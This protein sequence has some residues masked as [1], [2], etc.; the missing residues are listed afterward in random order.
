MVILKIPH[1]NQI[2]QKMALLL[3]CLFSFTTV[4]ASDPNP[5][6]NTPISVPS[7]F[8]LGNSDYCPLLSIE[9]KKS[10]A[11]KTY[12]QTGIG[13][14]IANES[15]DNAQPK[16]AVLVPAHVVWGAD[17]ITGRCNDKI[18]EFKI[19]ALSQTY[20]L[21]LL[22]FSRKNF[23][24]L[25]NTSI[26]LLWRGRAPLNLGDIDAA[27]T[28][29]QKQIFQELVIDH[30][31]ISLDEELAHQ[32]DIGIHYVLPGQEKN[33]KTIFTPT[34]WRSFL[35]PSRVLSQN[36][37]VF[38]GLKKTILL[39]QFAVRPGF[40]GSPLFVL[41]APGRYN[42]L[43]F[44]ETR[45]RVAL[46]RI[47][48]GMV[49]KT[50][51]NG[52]RAIA[53]S[54]EDILRV[55]PEL[56]SAE[57]DQDPY[58]VGH[59]N[60][61]HM[62]YAFDSEKLAKG[63]L[64]RRQQLIIPRQNK[65]PYLIGEFCGTF[66]DSSDWEPISRT[67][68]DSESQSRKRR[69]NETKV[70]RPPGGDYG[71]SGGTTNPNKGEFALEIDSD[72]GNSHF[73]SYRN[74]QSCPNPGLLLPS[75]KIINSIRSPRKK[76]FRRTLS[77]N[78]ITDL[79]ER[80]G[81]ALIALLE[82]EGQTANSQKIDIES[83]CN[84]QVMGSEQKLFLNYG[85]IG[86]PRFTKLL[87]EDP[88]SYSPFPNPLSYG[89]ISAQASRQKGFPGFT[90]ECSKSPTNK[91]L[92]INYGDATLSVAAQLSDRGLQGKVII[93]PSK[94]L[95]CAVDLTSENTKSSSVWRHQIRSEAMDLDI[96]F[97][98]QGRIFGIDLLRIGRGCGNLQSDL[99]LWLYEVDFTKEEDQ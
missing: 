3:A 17:T 26:P 47:L 74:L 12:S 53:I 67:T 60:Q 51:V 90:L 75:G 4:A 8:L 54:L 85:Q 63:E 22:D 27:T 32:Q 7:F 96:H 48:I 78:D 6:A 55:L 83:I 9:A 35:E 58:V 41:P 57:P 28:V 97:G 37:N 89:R 82:T 62:Q 38:L 18:T 91:V 95:E 39:N 45:S 10:I 16:V 84:D 66:K 50:E 19:T 33:S 80:D 14:I 94:L 43:L 87:K 2:Q 40:S 5:S 77:L 65:S 81:E 71:D 46:P 73:A 92:T 64:Q 25:G 93:R 79:A 88:A 34:D 24:E 69:S 44:D 13:W 99:G 72:E 49:V 11:T 36:Q 56:Q 23:E 52:S 76:I 20:D 30:A 21:A 15:R 42:S 61:A 70:A 68:L 86:R 29:R 31:P 1:F 98:S 59:P